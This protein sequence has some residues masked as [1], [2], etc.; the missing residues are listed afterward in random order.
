MAEDEVVKIA[1]WK[2]TID[3]NDLSGSL[4]NR[5]FCQKRG[6]QGLQIFFHVIHTTCH[7]IVVNP[8]VSD[9]S[10]YADGGLISLMGV[11][12]YISILSLQLVPMSLSNAAMYK[13]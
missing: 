5:F 4:K 3:T 11:T 8:V 12:D 13:C 10:P 1:T 2:T 7:R 6:Q 9:L